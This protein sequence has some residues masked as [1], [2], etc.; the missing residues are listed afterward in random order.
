M[1]S[2]MCIRDSSSDILRGVISA[3]QDISVVRVNRSADTNSFRQIA[4]ETV[5]TVTAD[6]L[7]SSSR[8]L[9]GLFYSSA[10]VVE[11][12]SDARFFGVA[13][14]QINNELDTH[15]VAA[16]NKQTVAKILKLYSEMGVKHLGIVDFD[17]LRIVAELEDAMNTLEVSE[18]SIASVKESQKKIAE[19][20]NKVT[21]EQRIE[22]FKE[23]L[24][25]IKT[26]LESYD[27]SENPN[28]DTVLRFLQKRA[29]EAA[30][31]TKPWKE[32]KELGRAGLSESA[33]SEFDKIAAALLP[34]GLCIYQFGELESSL[35][36][37][38]L[39]YTTNKKEW[40]VAALKLVSSLSV[41]LDKKFWS[42]MNRFSESLK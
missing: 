15:F 22:T 14:T 36:E 34:H 19:E 30:N 33:A 35:V 11:S 20:A 8:V 31:V 26:E 5:K 18:S 28:A 2:E 13:L 27:S 4:T 16:D 9:E 29:N 10:V 38:G 24:E 17:M 7:L 6:P 1:G 37:F 25:R 40:I 23:V 41:D 39:N 3:T 21:T 12:D 42:E 32:L